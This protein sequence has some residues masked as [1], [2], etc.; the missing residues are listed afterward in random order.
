MFC[1]TNTL[2]EEHFTRWIQFIVKMLHYHRN[3]VE[4][5]RYDMHSTIQ[6]T[7]EYYELPFWETNNANKRRKKICT[8]LYN[9]WKR[10]ISSTTIATTN[11]SISAELTLI[12]NSHRII[13]LSID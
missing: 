4:L 2:W 5:I 8:N 12:F 13:L 7:D 1:K 11:N 9:K 6:Q 3:Q 10:N